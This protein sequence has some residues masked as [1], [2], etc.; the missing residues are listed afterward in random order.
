MPRTRSFQASRDV[1]AGCQR[2]HAGNPQWNGP[3]AQGLA[4]QHHDRTGHETWVRVVMHI[5][6]G[7]GKQANSAEPRLL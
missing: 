4:A 6:Y 5:R 7:V 3:S 1:A 2:C